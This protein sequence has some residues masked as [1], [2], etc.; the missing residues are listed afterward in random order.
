MKLNRK[1]LTR[2][3]GDHDSPTE[4]R[5]PLHEAANPETQSL[6]SLHKCVS[7][8][9]PITSRTLRNSGWT[10]ANPSSVELLLTQLLPW[11]MFWMWLRKIPKVFLSLS[12]DI[13]CW[14][15]Q[16]LPLT[17]RI[18]G[19]ALLSP[20][21]QRAAPQPLR[22]LLINL[23]IRLLWVYLSAEVS[24]TAPGS[25][26]ILLLYKRLNNYYSKARNKHR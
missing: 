12:D 11:K 24:V 14:G 4:K 26:D 2:E 10:S 3:S 15:H 16:H 20:A 9:C 6:R 18:V 13:P 22:A 25:K 7:Q 1:D 19:T 5:E 21:Q 8:D 23:F 17:A